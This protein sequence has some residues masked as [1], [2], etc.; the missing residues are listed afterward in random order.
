[1]NTIEFEHVSKLYPGETKPALK[2]V[3]FSVAEGEFVCLI[4]AS[5]C[6]KTTV[7]KLIAGLEEPTGGVVKKPDKVSMA[8]QLGALFPWLTVFENAALGLRQNGASD[9]E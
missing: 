8:F 3:T 1:M 4:G 2:D 9:S 5:G 6:G 7:L